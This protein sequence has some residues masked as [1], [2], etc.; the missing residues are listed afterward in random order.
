MIFQL[1]IDRVLDRSKTHTMR[2]KKPG[3]A[4][5]SGLQGW[6]VY[7]ANDRP[8]WLIGH[9]YAVQR[10]RGA[11]SEARIKVLAI[12]EFSNPWDISDALAVREGFANRAEYARSW[13]KLH[14]AKHTQSAF[15]ITFELVG[16]SN[17]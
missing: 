1:T 2:L 12:H 15:G 5:R 13:E 17:P 14:G 11:K 8:K 16:R 7:D 10:R 6:G 3:D 9:T 4:Y